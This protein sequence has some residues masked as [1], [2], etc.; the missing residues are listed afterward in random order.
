MHEVSV[1]YRGFLCDTAGAG[2]RVVWHSIAVCLPEEKRT[3]AA[4]KKQLKFSKIQKRGDKKE[5]ARHPWKKN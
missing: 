1:K 4:R 3:S 2:A 5:G